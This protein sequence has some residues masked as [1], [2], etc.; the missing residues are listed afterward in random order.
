MLINIRLLIKLLL[1]IMI[2][3]GTLLL[4][5]MNCMNII[6]I[7]ILQILNLILKEL[8]LLINN[9]GTDLIWIIIIIIK[10]YKIMIIN[11]LIIFNEFFSFQLFL[12]FIR[13]IFSNQ[14]LILQYI[15]C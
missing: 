8:I 6:N 13:K 10:L 7:Q 3:N 4:I 5:R 14:L 15:F 12:L 11:K 9:L 2:Y 1:L